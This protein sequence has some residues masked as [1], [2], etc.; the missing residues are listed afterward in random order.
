M[1]MQI[2]GA[3]IGEELLDPGNEMASVDQLPADHHRIGVEGADRKR[4]RAQLLGH[5]SSAS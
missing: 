4:A 3:R 2:R 1:D 5:A